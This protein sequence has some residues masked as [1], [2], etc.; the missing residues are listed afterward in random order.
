MITSISSVFEAAGSDTRTSQWGGVWTYL[1]DATWTVSKEGKVLAARNWRTL[2]NDPHLQAVAFCLVA[3][4]LGD[5]LWFRSGW[6]GGQ[7]TDQ[8]RATRKTINRIV[9]RSAQGADLDAGGMLCQAD[10]DAQLLLS[11]FFSGNGWAVRVWN[12][13]RPGITTGSCWRVVDADRVETPPDKPAD[14][15][16]GV[17]YAGGSA[18][19]VYVRRFDPVLAARRFTSQRQAQYDYHPFVGDDGLRQ[20]LHYAPMRWRSDSDLGVPALAAGLMIAHQLRQ[21]FQAHVSGKRIQASH[22]IVLE[23]A[24]PAEAAKKYQEAVNAG[25]ADAD[26]QVLF[27]PKGS[28]TVFTNAQYNGSDLG[29]VTDVYLR[30]LCASIGYP[31]Q[32]VLCQLTDANLAA[33]QAALDQA[34]RTSAIYQRQW[35]EQAQ[36]HRDAVTIREGWARGELGDLAD[37]PD[38]YVGEWQRPRRADANR[39]RTRQAA[40]LAL[41]LGISPSTVCDEMGYDFESEQERTAEDKG[42]CERL[43]TRF[44]QDTAVESAPVPALDATDLPANQTTDAPPAAPAGDVRGAVRL[45]RDATGQV[46]GIEPVAC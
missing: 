17:R 12:P 33:A 35:I 31:W 30:A 14:V 43:Q 1:P 38:L 22:P 39:L 25:E 11:G 27:V 24:N 7:Q 28:G 44:P 3:Q 19:G 13:T 32:F 9:A 42:T 36:R 6:G 21:L 40:E 45:V 8:V 20:V 10:L 16:N 2:L 34:E 29:A 26:A 23:V 46:V 41:K 15:V 37:T 5:G 4:I 18:V